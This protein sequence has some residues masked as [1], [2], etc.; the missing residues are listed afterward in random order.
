VRSDGLDHVDPGS[1]LRLEVELIHKKSSDKR[2]NRAR[3]DE[4]DYTNPGNRN[5]VF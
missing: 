1:S 5:T 2:S 4:F 3:S